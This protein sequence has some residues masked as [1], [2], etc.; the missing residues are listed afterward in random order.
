VNRNQVVV[1]RH[2]ETE[3]SKS[4][5]HT[6]RTDLPLTSKGVEQAKAVAGL[7]AGREFALVLCSP[8]GRARQTCELAG[9]GEQAEVDDDLL[10]WDYGEMEGRKTVDIRDQYP[11]WTVWSG[12]VPGGETIEDVAVRAD[13]VIERCLAADGDAALFG[14]GHALRILT[15]RWCE[16]DPREGRRFPLAT[17]SLSE[18][19]WEHE[20]RTVLLWNA[21]GEPGGQ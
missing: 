19:S 16:L 8:L 2:G 10:E 20:Y 18:L 6:G 9:Y 5:Q 12:P 14:H 11:G 15:A 17:T 4:R 13:R 1:V 7:L 21:S 3:W